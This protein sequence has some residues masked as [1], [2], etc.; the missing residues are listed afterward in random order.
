MVLISISIPLVFGIALLLAGMPAGDKEEPPQDIKPPMVLDHDG[1]G[2]NAYSKEIMARMI[3]DEGAEAMESGWIQDPD[4]S[5]DESKEREVLP[6]VNSRRLPRAIGINRKGSSSGVFKGRFR[7]VNKD[8]GDS[9]L[10]GDGNPVFRYV[11]VEWTGEES[12][13]YIE[14]ARLLDQVLAE[15]DA[16]DASLER[17]LAKCNSAEEAGREL[18]DSMSKYLDDYHVYHVG[19]CPFEKYLPGPHS[20]TPDQKEQAERFAERYH[21]R[22]IEA[23]EIAVKQSGQTE[24]APWDSHDDYD[25]IEN[26]ARF[27]RD[28][29]QRRLFLQYMKD[30]IPEKELFLKSML[31]PAQW[32]R[33]AA[34][35]EKTSIRGQLNLF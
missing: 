9:A 8:I 14:N 25:Y 5:W 22:L 31:T 7:P 28:V 6:P 4:E 12:A 35:W 21:A 32:D 18:I 33:R 27:V 16:L 29:E 11:W 24:P 34:Y 13:L 1:T 20:L 30:I 15:E 19:K 2:K 10:D 3:L 23:W 17:K 26:P